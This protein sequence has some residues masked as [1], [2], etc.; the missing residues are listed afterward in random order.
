MALDPEPPLYHSVRPLTA[1]ST[2][3][4]QQQSQRCWSGLLITHIQPLS[5]HAAPQTHSSVMW[6]ETQ[7]RRSERSECE[8]QT[9][10]I[11]TSAGSIKAM[12]TAI[13]GSLR[14]KTG[15]VSQPSSVNLVLFHILMIEAA[16]AEEMLWFSGLHVEGSS[17]VVTGPP[18]FPPVLYLSLFLSQHTPFRTRFWP[19]TSLPGWT[20]IVNRWAVC[21]ALLCLVCY[22]SLTLWCWRDGCWSIREM[23]C[24]IIFII[25]F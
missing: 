19:V 13:W 18:F 12:S 15:S 16:L 5:D 22:I 10:L 23:Y 6:E 20:Q 2:A 11:R 17:H 25:L 4:N 3:L 9:L 1:R 7:I 21:Q 24:K 8:Q 14:L